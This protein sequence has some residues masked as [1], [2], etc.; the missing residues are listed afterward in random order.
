MAQLQAPS[1][2]PLVVKASANSRGQ[3][4]V[5]YILLLSFVL[6]LAVLSNSLLIRTVDG[7][8]VKLGGAL[9][10]NLKSGRGRILVQP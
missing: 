7:A 10:Q 4:T 5:E 1:P 2:E 8:I 6:S 9:T 3:A